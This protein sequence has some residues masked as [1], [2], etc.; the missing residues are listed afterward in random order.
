MM[1][2]L[3]S[4]D[5]LNVRVYDVSL[6]NPIQKS[7]PLSEKPLMS[8]LLSALSSIFDL[9]PAAV[10]DMVTVIF[11][12]G[13]RSFENR[14]A[15]IS[16]GKP[17]IRTSSFSWLSTTKVMVPLSGSAVA[18][19]LT[20]PPQVFADALSGLAAG[21]GA[22]VVVVSGTSSVTVVVVVC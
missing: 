12:Y 7:L 13:S 15:S 10:E 21:A 17:A 18:D 9:E 20:F 11:L 8:W 19:R 22:V 4:V 1:P 2:P 5:Y 14:S 6:K 3:R 16:V